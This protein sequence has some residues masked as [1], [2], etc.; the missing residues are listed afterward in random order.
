MADIMICF[1]TQA[2]CTNHLFYI[3]TRQ[4]GFF[5]KSMAASILNPPYLYGNKVHRLE[6][7]ICI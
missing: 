6:V 5:N 7:Y 2:S 4:C 1:K 3:K